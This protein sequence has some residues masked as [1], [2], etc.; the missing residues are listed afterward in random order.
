MYVEGEWQYDRFVSLRKEMNPDNLLSILLD[1]HSD[2]EE[3]GIDMQSISEESEQEN[4]SISESEDSVPDLTSGESDDE[5][6][7]LFFV[8]E[9]GVTLD[10]LPAHVTAQ[11]QPLD[12]PA[13]NLQFVLSLSGHDTEEEND[14]SEDN[15]SQFL[16]Q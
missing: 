5:H 13:V 6:T 15:S 1:Q 14:E 12:M 3:S 7:P 11:L 8:D 9:V 16:Q 2:S 10:H 4:F